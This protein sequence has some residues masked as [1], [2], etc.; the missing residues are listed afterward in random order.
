MANIYRVIYTHSHPDQQK[1]VN[2]S[3][4]TVANAIAAAKA[5]DSKYKDIVTVTEKMDSVIAGS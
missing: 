5:A 2:V 1:A 3:A 4:T